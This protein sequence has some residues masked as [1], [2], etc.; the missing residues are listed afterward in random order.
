MTVFLREL[1]VHRK[2]MI[3][4][5]IAIFL[6]IISSIGKFNAYAQTGQSM[7]E[8]LAQIPSSIKAVLGM[9]NF[10]LTKVS[11]FYGML[12][13]YLLLLA[14]IHAALLGAN[15]ISKE[16]RDKTTEFLLVKPISRSKLISAKLLA[17]LINIVVV[18]LVTLFFS[19]FLMGKYA[20]GTGFTSEICILM[21]GMFILQLMFL[22][23]GTATA[24]ASKKP[25]SAPSVATA[26]LLIT[27]LI[28]SVINM[29][30]NLEYLKY[31]TPFE[32][33]KAE[34]LLNGEGFETVFLILSLI[35]IVGL[36]FVTY[37]SY[38]SRDLN[39]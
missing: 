27:F 24:A 7:N 14:T 35:I 23:I 28:S 5:S 33:F 18:N 21:V 8:L 29:N 16:E 22:L 19:V 32:Y 3:I 15:I 4:W 11:G 26:I 25:R 13:W 2:S 17:C 6:M 1:K 10:D 36:G 30:S 37:V 12:Y 20:N 31:I 39:V 34:R 38:K 9:G